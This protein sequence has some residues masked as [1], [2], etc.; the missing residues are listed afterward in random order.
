M[1]K[2]IIFD[3]DGVLAISNHAHIAACQK[4]LKEAGIKRKIRDEDIT[5][6]FGEAY[7]IV[8]RNLMADEY[9]EGKLKF[10]IDYHHKSIHSDK[11]LE[12][13]HKIDGL[14][15]L[16]A[17]LK[18]KNLRLAIASGN[19]RPFINKALKFLGMGGLFDLVVGADDVEKSKP[20]PDMLNKAIDFFG[21]LPGEALFVG[22]AKND[23]ISAKSAGV[24]SAA[25]LTGILN[26]K[27][28]GELEPDFILSDVLELGKILL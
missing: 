16:L 19:D 3:L 9:T 8:L 1:F 12:D 7:E 4:S 23:I 14:N 13:I 24:K 26:K 21:I 18:K 22:D 25:V 5:P 28:A 11:F 2:L 6:F 10:A 17:E 27:T 15:E 20:A